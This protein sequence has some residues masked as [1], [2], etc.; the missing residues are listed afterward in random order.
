MDDKTLN[1]RI[2]NKKNTKLTYGKRLNHPDS[3]K[4]VRA[5]LVKSGDTEKLAHQRGRKSVEEIAREK[6]KFDDIT[7]AITDFVIQNPFY[8]QKELMDFCM[9]RFG[10]VFKTSK[11]K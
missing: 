8:N 9:S 5:E 4:G 11:T 10:E 1:R 7:D 3:Y 2:V 6:G